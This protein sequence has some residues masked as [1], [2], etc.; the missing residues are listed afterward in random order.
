MPNTAT[1]TSSPATSTS[2]SATL[3][4]R[5]VLGIAAT[6]IIALAAHLSFPLPFT[7][8]PLIMTPLAV[9]GAGLLF[10]PLGGFLVLMAYLAEGLAGLPVF[11]PSGPGGALQLL[12]PT[13]GYLMSYPLV[14]LVAGGLT[15][16][17]QKRLPTF[18]AATIACATA[19]TV[20]FAVGAAWFLHVMPLATPHLVWIGAVAPFLPGEAIKVLVAAGIYSTLIRARRA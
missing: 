19:I 8:V 10:G 7:P 1:L 14:A 20:L 9:L 11:S 6:G 2:Y 3:P 12:G 17:L 4:G 18:A 15:R 13:G 16:L 5:I